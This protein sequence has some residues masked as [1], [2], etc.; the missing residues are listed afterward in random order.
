M[1]GSENIKFSKVR[2]RKTNVI[3]HLYNMFFYIDS[4]VLFWNLKNNTNESIKKKQKQIHRHGKQTYGYQRRKGGG[5][6]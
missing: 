5:K 4:F 1:D 2:Q 3:Y 6:G